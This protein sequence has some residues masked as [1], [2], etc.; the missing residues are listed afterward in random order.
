MMCL[1]PSKMH[2]E[3]DVCL[4]KMKAHI[5]KFV[6][7][8]KLSGGVTT[9]NGLILVVLVLVDFGADGNFIDADLVA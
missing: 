3:R 5:L 4:Q 2:S 6:H 9:V 7:D 1:D 8:K